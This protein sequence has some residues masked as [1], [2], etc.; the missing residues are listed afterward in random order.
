MTGEFAAFLVL[1][2]AAQAARERGDYAG[3]TFLLLKA[4]P[5]LEMQSPESGTLGLLY[6]ELAE[7]LELSGD[8]HQAEQWNRKAS[9][10]IIQRTSFFLPELKPALFRPTFQAPTSKDLSLLGSRLHSLESS[11]IIP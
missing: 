2:A 11:N 8:G 9:E 7:C 6:L 1:Q 3:A 5:G 4:V 10:V